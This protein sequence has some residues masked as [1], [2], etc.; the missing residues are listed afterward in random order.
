MR[1][2]INV[3]KAFLDGAAADA[4]MVGVV[5]EA[6]TFYAEAG[7][8]VADTGTITTASGASFAVADVKKFGQYVLHIGEVSAGTLSLGDEVTLS[9]DYKRRAPIAKN[10]TATHMLNL[11]IK[12]ALGQVRT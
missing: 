9:V 8:Q 1:A 12:E 4:G 10:H 11:A 3:K 2:I 5:T 7:G 6:T